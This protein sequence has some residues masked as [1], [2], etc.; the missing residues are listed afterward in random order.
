[1]TGL[2]SQ[3]A[4][5]CVSAVDLFY[6]LAALVGVN[7]KGRG[8]PTDEVNTHWRGEMEGGNKPQ[9][10]AIGIKALSKWQFAQH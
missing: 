9:V 2:T 10:K 7:L 1:L 6:E 5:L 8:P 4:A 3:S